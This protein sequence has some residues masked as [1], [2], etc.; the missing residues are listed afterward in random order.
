MSTFQPAEDALEDLDHDSSLP[1]TARRPARRGL[2]RALLTLPLAAV[3]VLAT[4]VSGSPAQAAIYAGSGSFG[5]HAVPSIDCR[6]K[7]YGTTG[8]LEMT[9]TPPTVYTANFRAGAGNDGSYVRYRVFLVDYNTKQ[10]L[11]ASGYSA[12]AWAKDNVPAS[13]SGFTQFS[14]SWR[15]HYL[16]DYRIEWWNPGASQPYAWSAYRADQYKYVAANTVAGGVWSSC[17]KV[18]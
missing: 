5:Y 9:A 3:L 16:I 8:V 1:A 7:T 18:Y 2:V 13:W 6:H 17:M 10:T 15:G 14:P 11:Q 4:L 12:F